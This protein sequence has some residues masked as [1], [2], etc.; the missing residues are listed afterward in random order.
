MILNCQSGSK[1]KE[2]YLQPL[3]SSEHLPYI[4]EFNYLRENHSEVVKATKEAERALRLEVSKHEEVKK[5]LE[6]QTS[7]NDDFQSQIDRART[8]KEKKRGA[9]RHMGEMEVENLIHFVSADVDVLIC[10]IV[11]SM[12]LFACH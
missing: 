8:E 6:K 4:V 12:F 10:F 1:T 7:L 11:F 5:Q 9:T 3:Q 2:V